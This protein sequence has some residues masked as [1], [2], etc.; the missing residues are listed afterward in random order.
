MAKKPSSSKKRKVSAGAR[1]PQASTSSTNPNRAVPSSTKCGKS[2]LRSKSTIERLNMYRSKPNMEKRR[3]KPTKP[4]RIE[5]DRRWFGNTRVITQTKLDLFRNEM[6]KALDDPYNVILKRSKLP[7]SLVTESNKETKMHLLSVESFESTFGKNKQRKRPKLLA[8]DLEDVLQKVGEGQ[9]TYTHEKDRTLIRESD[10]SK[11]AAS[12]EIF[13]KGTSKRIWME[14]YKVIDSSDVLIQVLDARDPDGTRCKRFEARLRKDHPNK[15][16]ILLLNKCDLIPA[17]VAERWTKLYSREYP[18]VAFHSSI[19]RPFGKQT[20]LQLLRQFASL[21]KDRKH[22]SVGFFGYPNVGKSSVIN[23]LRKKKVCKAAPTPGETRIW[24]Y[25]S[26]TNRIYLIDCPGIVPDEPGSQNETSKVLKGV[27]RAERIASP[28]DHIDEVISRVERD[29]LINRY[30]LP[31][32]VAFHD[33]ES[34]LTVVANKMGK[35]L[36]AGEPD[37]STAARIVLYDWQRGRLPFYS[38]PP[39]MK[40]AI[41]SAPSPEEEEGENCKI[42]SVEENPTPS[43]EVTP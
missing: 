43:N 42:P 31:S 39:H 3:E 40:K 30:R 28:E 11:E 14:L 22:V 23:T 19:S 8:N 26:L 5:P 29:S 7:L 1:R 6:K 24:Q 13:K 4:A 18:T 41:R 10:G 36:K 27:V 37:I 38:L 15:H 35:L 32:D 34:F 20:L 2:S 33:S 25:I 21:M 16:L 12:E 9:L 17:W